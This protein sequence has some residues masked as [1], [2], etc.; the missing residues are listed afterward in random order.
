MSSLKSRG[1]LGVVRVGVDVGGTKIAIGAAKI[2][3]RVLEERVTVPASTEEIALPVESLEKREAF[4]KRLAGEIFSVMLLCKQRG[5]RIDGAIG[6]GSPGNIQDGV[7]LPKTA[8]QLGEVFDHF[9]LAKGLALQLDAVVSANDFWEWV[10]YPCERHFTVIARNDALAQ[11]A[12]AVSELWKD[13]SFEVMIAR[14]H[15]PRIAYIGPGT[16]LGGGFAEVEKERKLKFFTDGHIGDI[17]MGRDEAGR[18][19]WAERDF[20]S[21]MY[22]EKKM[23]GLSGKE[24][25]QSIPLYAEFIRE[26]GVNLGKIIEKIHLGEVYK[27]RATTLWSDLDRQ[28]VKGIE[29]FIIGGSIGS[30]GRMGEIIREEAKRYLDNVQGKISGNMHLIPVPTDAED[31][32]VLGAISFISLS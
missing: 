10:E 18:A 28:M 21:G 7:I 27:A 13:R 22:I 6:V 19:L 30:K 16:G 23:N 31:A 5:Y 29:I 2:G 3:S 1:G 8:P 24:L 20:L 25:A 32:G 12:F 15:H 4:I 9:N 17:I 26:L 11:M 14:A